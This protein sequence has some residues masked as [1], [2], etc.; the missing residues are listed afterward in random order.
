MKEVIGVKSLAAMK[1]LISKTFNLKQ[2]YNPFRIRLS[3]CPNKVFFRK[4][5]INLKI[6]SGKDGWI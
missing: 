2:Q 1:L 5:A 3:I 6:L 4:V